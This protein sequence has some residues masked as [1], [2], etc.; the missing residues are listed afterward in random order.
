MVAKI[1][2]GK[3]IPLL[4]KEYPDAKCSLDYDSPFQ[5]IV[6]TILSAQCTDARVNMVTPVLFKKYSTP[7]KLARA[8]LKDIEEIIR[9][10]GFYK[11][12]AKSL[13]EMAKSLVEKH[14][15]QVP[16]TMDELVH[17]RGVGR[18][19]ANV[20]LGNAFGINEGVVVDTH[21]GRLSRRMGFTKE[22]DPVK[23]EQDLMKLVPQKLWALFSHFLV[24]H[25]RKWCSARKPLCEGCPIAPYCPRIGV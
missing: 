18:K 16:K 9:S 14:K 13:S 7:E 20:V 25:G 17:L 11:N 3:I 2:I 15:G 5:L 1:R 23:V 21:V 24:F 8:P 12:K 19:T 22:H 6:A 4:K 10:T